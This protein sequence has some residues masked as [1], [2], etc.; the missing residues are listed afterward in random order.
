M[1]NCS[2]VLFPCRVKDLIYIDFHPDLPA[3]TEVIITAD[4][5]VVETH[6]Y[7]SLKAAKLPYDV[8][9][10]KPGRYI[11]EVMIDGESRFKRRFNKE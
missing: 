8:S 10:L 9:Y 4:G 3:S 11:M 2:F 7:V 6:R 1:N 5:V